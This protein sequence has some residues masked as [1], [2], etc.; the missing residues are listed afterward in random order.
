LTLDTWHGC[1]LC[2]I[3][4][5]SCTTSSRPGL[6]TVVDQLWVLH[7]VDPTTLI[8]PREEYVDFTYNST[9]SLHVHHH[10]WQRK[11]LRNKKGVYLL[12]VCQRSPSFCM[13]YSTANKG[14]RSD[15][16]SNWLVTSSLYNI[17]LQLQSH[18]QHFNIRKRYL[19]R[20]KQAILGLLCFGY[21]NLVF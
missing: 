12:H 10:F 15:D 9:S 3:F 5:Y 19:K 2:F 8:L 7:Y 20:T 11:Y 21:S 6:L 17:Y 18:H 1:L 13:N 16:K 14:E 4:L